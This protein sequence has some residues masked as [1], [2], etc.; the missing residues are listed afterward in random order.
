MGEVV[1]ELHV[2]GLETGHIP[3][4]MLAQVSSVQAYTVS[5]SEGANVAKLPHTVENF[6]A[7]AAP[8]L[9]CPVFDWKV[10]TTQMKTIADII[11]TMSTIITSAMIV[12][13]P[14]FE[15]LSER[16]TVVPS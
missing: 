13:K 5:G 8:E 11:I 6:S 10:G 15:R 9:S 4:G 7:Y 2:V 1:G 16:R 12:L 14:L 3:D